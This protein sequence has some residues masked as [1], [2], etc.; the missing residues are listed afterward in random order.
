MKILAIIT[1][2]AL[3]LVFIGCDDKPK[4][5]QRTFTI[6]LEGYDNPVTVK[7]MR[8]GT[9]DTALD[10]LG[11]ISRLKTGLEGQLDGVLDRAMGYGLIIE[12]EVTDVYRFQARSGNRMGASIGYILSDD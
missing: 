11:V 12:A 1:A 3:S 9:N 10:T 5:I 8:T 4:E 2:I 7:D 6:T